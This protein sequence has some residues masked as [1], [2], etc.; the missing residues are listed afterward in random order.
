MKS[1]FQGGDDKLKIVITPE[2][3]E[4]ELLD[5]FCANRFLIAVPHYYQ[6]SDKVASVTVESMNNI[7]ER[8]HT[9]HHSE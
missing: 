8:P 2:L 9:A 1:T 6:H 4:Q 5:K 7:P 3:D